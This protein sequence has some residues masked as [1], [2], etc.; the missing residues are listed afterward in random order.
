LN[1][2]RTPPVVMSA[3]RIESKEYELIQIE[4]EYLM[5]LRAQFKLNQKGTPCVVMNAIRIESN[6]YELNQVKKEHLVLL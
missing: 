4:R 6:E 2:K 3:I 5:L 1:Q